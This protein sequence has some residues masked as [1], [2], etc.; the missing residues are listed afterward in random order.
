MA[1]NYSYS[2]EPTIDE[3]ELTYHELIARG[4]FGDVYRV[5]W[6]SKYLGELEAA[7][8]K[9]HIPRNQKDISKDLENEIRFLQTLKHPNII[10]F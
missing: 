7:A 5:T 10:K 8:K 4:G 6:N 3:S 1:A 9:I 2:L